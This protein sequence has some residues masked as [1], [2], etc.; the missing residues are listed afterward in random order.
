[1]NLSTAELAQV[2]HSVGKIIHRLKISDI[3]FL[4]FHRK[5]FDTFDTHLIV[6]GNNLK[7]SSKFIF[8]EK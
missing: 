7:E 3:F 1:M 6:S 2:K 8:C 4:G 5:E